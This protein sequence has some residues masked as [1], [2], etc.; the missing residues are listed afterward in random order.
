MTDTIQDAEFEQGM[1]L[2][3]SEFKQQYEDEFIFDKIHLFYKD[4]P[5]IAKEPIKNLNE[6]KELFTNGYF[7]S[8]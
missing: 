5:N 2:L 7:P 8:H 3:Y 6:S 4:N 1:E